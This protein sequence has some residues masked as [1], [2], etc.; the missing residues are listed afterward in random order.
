[1]FRN[2]KLGLG[3]VTYNVLKDMDLEALIAVCEKTAMDAVEL[4]T[5][6]AHGVEVSLSADERKAVRDR[7]AASPLTLAALG[8]TCEFHSTD[9]AVVADNV[10][11]TRE[12]CRLAADVGALGVKV[13]PNALPEGSSESDTTRRIALALLECAKA[14]ED[15]GV[16]VFVEVHGPGTSDP[17]CMARIMEQCEHPSLGVTW[18]CNASDMREGSIAET[19]PPLRDRVMMVHTHDWYED[20]PYATELIPCLLGMGFQGYC[21]AEMPQTPDTER[22]LRYYR[23]AFDI[24]V[25]ACSG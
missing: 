19:F 6:H 13:R 4:R 7:F 14:A 1:M 18:N 25:D 8:S 10:A 22:V 23:F 2:G 24:M 5:T 20:Y 9:P 15:L 11:L 21:L 17:A 16:R 3:V 12:F